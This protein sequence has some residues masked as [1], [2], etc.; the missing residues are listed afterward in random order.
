MGGR[1]EW[2]DHLGCVNSFTMFVVIMKLNAQNTTED[3]AATREDKARDSG[4]PNAQED[5]EE[6]G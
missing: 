6:V 3:S 4:S 2:P 1:I 5:R